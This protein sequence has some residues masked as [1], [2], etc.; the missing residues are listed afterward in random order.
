MKHITHLLKSAL[1]FALLSFITITAFAQGWRT[2]EME[3]KVLL[4][5]SKDAQTLHQLRLNGDIYRDYALM[6]VTPEELETVKSAGLHYDLTK[7]NLNEY[8][9]DFWETRDAYHTYDQIIYIMDSLAEALPDLVTKTVYGT[10]VGGRELS[11]LKISDNVAVDENEPEIGFD[12]NIHGDEIGGGENMIRFARWLCQQYGDNPQITDLINN[13]EI[14]IYPLVNPDGRVNLTRYN[15]NGIDLNRDW[16]YN[17]NGE[18]SSPGAYSQPETKALRQMVLDNQFSIHMTFHSGIELYLHPWYFYEVPCP[19][20]DEE[21]MLAQMYSSTSGYSNLE[22]GPGTSLYP[23]TGSTAESYYGVKGSHGI[24][25][26]LSYDKQPPVSQIGYY[27]NINLQPCINLIEYAGYGLQGLVTD[28]QTGD[29]VPAIIYVGNNMTCF[30]DPEVGDYHKFVVG[31]TYTIKVKANGYQTQMISN[32][33]VENLAITTLNIQL[34]P[35]EHQS[36]YQVCSSQRPTASSLNEQPSWDVIGPPDNLYYSLAKNGWMVFDMQVLVLDGAGSDLI[37]FEGDATAEGFELYAGSSIDGPWILLGE[38]SGTSEF[39]LG[40]SSITEARYFKIKD[41]GDGGNEADAGFDLD[42]AQSMSSISGPYILMEG[43]TINDEN[44]NNNGQLDPGESAEITLTL[45]NIGTEDATGV[46]GELNTADMYVTV[47]TTEPQLLGDLIIGGTAS[48]TFD[49]SA[50]QN[51]PAGHVSTLALDFYGDNELSGTKFIDLSFPDYCY[52]TANCSFGDGFTGFALEQID[53]LNNGCSND[54]GVSAYGNFTDL[55]A[56]LSAGETYTVQWESGYDEQY[57]C[58]WIDLN[59]DKD[60]GL[61]ELYIEDFGLENSGQLYSAQFEVPQNASPGEHRL[62]IRAHWLESAA[63]PCSSF[64]YGETEDYT[65]VIEPGNAITPQFSADNNEFC[66]EG[67][68]Q[69]TDLSQGTI[70]EWIWNFPGGEP[71]TSTEQNPQVFY[72]QS[73]SYNVSLTVSNSTN[74]ETLTLENYIVVHALPEVTFAPL[75]TMCLDWPAYQLTEGFP[76]GGEY[77]GNG[78]SNGWFHPDVAGPGNHII[79]YTYVDEYACENIDEQSVFVDACTGISERGEVFT[80]HPNPSK[81]ILNFTTE[82][83]LNNAGIS[84]VNAYGLAIYQARKISIQ[85]N[86]N[87]KIDLTGAAPGLYFILLDADQLTIR[88]IMVE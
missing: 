13:R 16:G 49:V 25:M 82:Q 33:I 26:E 10:S 21:E 57:A 63:D 20:I 71:E 86:E 48:A 43:Y 74:T 70:T 58:L 60:F 11:A 50:E 44:G 23:T 75:E 52:P 38:G 72:A 64:S 12:G 4:N 51:T 18:G 65:I 81:G 45:K 47:I 30:S 9:K 73:G 22:T 59:D 54:N 69:F 31:G 85:T 40:N 19:D 7:E 8:Y 2:N 83:D 17:W 3:I 5:D 79:T 80:I 32:V 88:K 84:I 77:S 36:I 78:V 6:Y 56:T 37:V 35:E 24:V 61:N 34:E 46:F 1:T 66:K 15:N 67:A 28:A 76:E 14:W 27:F 29:P 39:D 42:A 68:V 62:R 87:Y 55:S 53:N 41:D